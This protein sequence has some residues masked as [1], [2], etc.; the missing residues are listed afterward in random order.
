MLT[1]F[2]N[3]SMVLVREFLIPHMPFLSA[4]K[5]IQIRMDL[6]SE[7]PGFELCLTSVSV[8]ILTFYCHREKKKTTS[9]L[10]FCL[11]LYGSKVDDEYS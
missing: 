7:Q 8:G 6:D 3:K 5:G 9:I 11:A 1:R 4:A 2:V 10:D